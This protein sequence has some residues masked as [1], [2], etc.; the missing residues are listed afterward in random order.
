M[1]SWK[2]G[3]YKKYTESIIADYKVIEN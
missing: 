1:Q 2:T 3:C